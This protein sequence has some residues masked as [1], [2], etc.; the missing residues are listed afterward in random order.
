M[1]QMNKPCFHAIKNHAV[2]AV[3]CLRVREQNWQQSWQWNTDDKRTIIHACFEYYQA[4]SVE[5]VGQSQ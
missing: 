2:K 5:S 3:G 1:A 4:S